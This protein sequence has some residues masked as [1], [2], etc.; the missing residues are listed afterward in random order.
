MEK[1]TRWQ[2]LAA[3]AAGAA[4]ALS[5]LVIEMGDTATWTMVILGIVT[6]V[7]ALGA[8]AEAEEKMSGYALVLLGALFIGSP[9][10]MDIA[11]TGNDVAVTAWVV[12]AVAV[13]AGLLTV[14]QV[15]ERMHH[16]AIPH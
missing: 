10:A 2:L 15:E 4:A 8:M 7:V 1:W 11:S 6:A 9:W 3:A 13:I 5:P 16:R 12:G 14:P